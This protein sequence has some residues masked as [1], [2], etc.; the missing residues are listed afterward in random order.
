MIDVDGLRILWHPSL[1]EQD[2]WSVYRD[3]MAGREELTVLC[4]EGSIALA[5]DGMFDIAGD[6]G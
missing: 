3:V 6:A 2:L 5:E 1:A 4:V